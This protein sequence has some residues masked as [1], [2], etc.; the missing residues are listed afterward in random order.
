MRL[1][2]LESRLQAVAP[3]ET[4]VVELEQ[5]PTSAHLASQ[6]VHAMHTRDDVEDKNILDLGCG[7][8]ILGIGCSLLGGCVVGVDIDENALRIASKNVQDQEVDIDLCRMDVLEL[9]GGKVFDT[10]IMNPPFGT[11]RRGVD[12][13]F[14][15][16]G[17]NMCCGVV[18]SLHKSSTRGY[19][20]KK[21]RSWGA[22][23]E[24][25]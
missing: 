11:K 2:E 10:V 7:T 22:E 18:Y 3:F 21:A 8:G 20:E 1:W 6:I 25:G 12:I 24:V 4:P 14:L 13:G 15:K 23:A 16:K 5:Y 19:I 17:V 9:K